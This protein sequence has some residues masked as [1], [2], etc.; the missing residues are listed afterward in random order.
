MTNQNIDLN[1]KR[2]SNRGEEESEIY[3]TIADVVAKTASDRGSVSG[4]C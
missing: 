1:L 3:T 2:W 4:V